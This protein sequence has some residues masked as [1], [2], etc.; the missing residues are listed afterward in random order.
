[1]SESVAGKIS[2][3]SFADYIEGEDTIINEIPLSDLYDFKDH[4]FRV[5]DDE[6]MAETVES[7]KTFG[8]LMPG[9][10]RPRE[11]GGYEIISGHRRKRACEIAGL[12]TMP[13]IIRDY[14]D[15]EAVVA[16]VDTNIQR[17]DILPSEKANAY[18]MKY[19]ARKHQGS[20]GGKTL[21]EI[22]EVAGESGKT[23]QRYIWLSNLSSILLSYVDE[24]R[25]PIKSGVEI[26]FLKENEQKWVEDLIK[27]NGVNIAVDKAE[28]IKGYSKRK[29][30]TKA[31]LEEI[32]LEEK[33]KPRKFV[34]KNDSIS[35]YF[36]E[37]VSDEEIEKTIIM[38]LEQWKHR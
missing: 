4:P 18:R 7:I 34:M 26:S 37:D 25:L 13:V 36:P 32:L 24:K 35:K 8:V 2:I 31:L 12:E 5:L 33:A 30:L 11:A 28:R 38:L 23:V 27:T 3:D 1:M 29:E 15:D 17:E 6:K 21:D 9:I 16:M 22:G 19:K 20:Q 14:N 10:V